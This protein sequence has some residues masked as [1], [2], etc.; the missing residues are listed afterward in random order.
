MKAAV[1]AQHQAL[2]V[3]ALLYAGVEVA[4]FVKAEE[5]VLQK[6]QGAGFVQPAAG[7]IRL[8]PGPHILVKPANGHMVVAFQPQTEVE[9]AKGL[10]GLPEAAG[11]IP[12][13]PG[14]HLG[15]LLLPGFPGGLFVSGCQVQQR[16]DHPPAPGVGGF[17]DSLQALGDDP[18]VIGSQ[19]RLI[20]QL[21]N[22]MRLA[23]GLPFCRGETIGNGGH[24]SQK[25]DLLAGQQHRLLQPAKHF[26]PA[27]HPL[28]GLQP[29]KRSGKALKAD[30]TA[31]GL[32]VTGL[33]IFLQTHKHSP[34]TV[35]ISD[36]ILTLPVNNCKIS[37]K[38]YLFL[39]ERL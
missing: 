16:V 13:H 36:I 21:V 23:D 20:A 15:Q 32:V 38:S 3:V 26:K 27:G 25:G 17:F 10:Q 11:A 29:G 33:D 1:A 14:Q 39:E 2:A 8:Q 30:L 18:P 6:G 28:P 24:S 12:G 22:K 4:V 19:I 31:V 35:M 34:F 7:K 9:D 37:D 5:K